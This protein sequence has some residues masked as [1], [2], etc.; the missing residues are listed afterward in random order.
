MTRKHCLSTLILLISL[1]S[2]SAAY[3]IDELPVGR[4]AT[5][6]KPQ[7]KAWYHD[8][9]WWCI[10]SDG[11]EG[12][13]FY[14]LI[15]GRWKK[16]TLP[17]A[18]VYPKA[19]TRAD[20][21]S[22]GDT[23]FVLAWEAKAPRLYKYTYENSRKS[24]HL[25]T[26]FPVELEAP[27]GHETM[28]IAQD[29]W[30]RLWI[31]FELDGKVKVIYSTSQD[32]RTWNTK[33]VNIAKGLKDDDIASAIAFNG[34]IGV[35]WSNQNKEALYF[36]I[37]RD[38]DPPD[39][40]RKREVVVKGELV[41]DD[42]IN[43]ALADDGRI[44]AVTKTSVDD[45]K[46]PVKGLIDAQIILSVRSRKGKWKIHDVAEVSP[47]FK[48][49]PIIVLDEEKN[50]IYVFYTEDKRIVSKRSPMSD[51]RFDNPL[52]KILVKPGVSLNNVTSTKQNVTSRT[53]LLI[54]STGDDDKMYSRLIYNKGSNKPM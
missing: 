23:L 14:G 5:A 35:F 49:R 51:I 21:L 12:S 42:H 26:G 34:Q 32:H 25:L 48:T 2:L 11:E 38:G 31:P 16:G 40:W 13:Y 46:E 27:K 22:M 1:V 54:L 19:N 29:S 44:F 30:G 7:S 10:L 43:L 17:D 28:V 52:V 53:G 47:I 24:Y 4:D 8:G 41:A 15:N 36:R 33:G 9:L 18:L 37:H 6:D 3:V 50:D 45:A 20:V 39:K